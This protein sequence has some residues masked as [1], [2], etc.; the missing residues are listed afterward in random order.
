[1]EVLSLEP[2]P[3]TACAF[4]MKKMGVLKECVVV[5]PV[6]AKYSTLVPVP[7]SSWMSAGEPLLF[8]IVMSVSAAAVP[9]GKVNTALAQLFAL[10]GLQ[11]QKALAESS[12]EAQPGWAITRM[13]ANAKIATSMSS[14]NLMTIALPSW[15]RVR[16]EIKCEFTLCAMSTNSEKL[17]KL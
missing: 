3:H 9:A 6:G 15:Y 10:A 11:L 13:N 17:I 8:A 5:A 12:S 7:S 2:F 16:Q 14:H 1:M 4:V